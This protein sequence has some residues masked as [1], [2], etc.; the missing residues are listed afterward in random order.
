MKL[1]STS[2]F[3]NSALED[4]KTFFIV[5]KILAL[6]FENFKFEEDSL[7]SII[8]PFTSTFLLSPLA[9]NVHSEVSKITC[10]LFKI[11]NKYNKFL[12]AINLFNNLNKSSDPN[13]FT[14]TM[15][16]SVYYAYQYKNYNQV[17]EL[18]NNFKIELMSSNYNDH[19]DY[20]MFQ[21]YR[22]LIALSQRVKII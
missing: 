5:M 15:A 11:L 8:L 19:I 20:C 21:F 16:Y 14:N 12:Y 1:F 9:K 2:S 17:S 3:Q 10:A 6:F 4:Q 7:D 13:I 18:L 22:G